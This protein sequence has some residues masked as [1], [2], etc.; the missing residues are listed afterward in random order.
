MDRKG[1]KTRLDQLVVACGL[2]STRQKAKA[3][4]MAGQ[5]LV[6]GR[7]VDKPGTFVPSGSS[8]DLIR[9]GTS[10]VS[11]GGL[12]LE[13]ALHHF[14]VDVTGLTI[15]DVG[16]S[17]GGFSD[18][19]LKHGAGRIIAIDVGY[20]QLDWTLRCDPRIEVRERTNARYLKPDEFDEVIDG[21]VID[22]SFI[23]LR[24]IVPAVMRLLRKASFIIALI[25]PQFE[26][27]KGQ[28]GKGGV[29]RDSAL[30]Q[31]VIESLDRF[32]RDTGLTP[33]GVIPSPILGPKG[34]REFLT[35]LKL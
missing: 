32:F 7:R 12:K 18:C 2:C 1:E 24:L 5:V 8:I 11:R 6:D 26:V 34:N 21:A 16:A 27:G 31:E 9:K 22:V 28:V 4:I 23:S 10:Y 35:H 25:K 20:G 19:L 3:V 13:Q 30:H 29:V 33:D 17:T 14:S 15:M